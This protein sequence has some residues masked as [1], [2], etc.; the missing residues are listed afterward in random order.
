MSEKRRHKG[1]YRNTV[2]Q[3]QRE[4]AVLAGA[5]CTGQK[6]RKRRP[7]ETGGKDQKQGIG[8]ISA[9]DNS[10]LR[11]QTLSA[12]TGEKQGLIRWRQ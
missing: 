2:R 6:D 1:A 9:W 10:I 7:E 12:V 11:K 5:A 8:G 3:G 4:K